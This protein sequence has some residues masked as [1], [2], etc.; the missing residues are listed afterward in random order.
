MKK[1]CVKKK[2]GQKEKGPR[3]AICAARMWVC[4]EDFM[5]VHISLE[6]VDKMNNRTLYINIRKVYSCND[7]ILT[8]FTLTWSDVFSHYSCCCCHRCALFAIRRTIR[9]MYFAADPHK[10]DLSTRNF[11]SKISF[12]PLAVSVFLSIF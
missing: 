11:S 8:K 1:S 6:N 5:R 12:F 3:D 9:K 2:Y 7:F 4:V 10:W